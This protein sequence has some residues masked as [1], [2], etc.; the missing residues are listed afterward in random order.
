MIMFVMEN[1]EN[2]Q[3]PDIKKARHS[4]GMTIVSI[5]A[6]VGLKRFSTNDES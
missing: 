4:S 6:T 2:S 5:T 3:K 1:K